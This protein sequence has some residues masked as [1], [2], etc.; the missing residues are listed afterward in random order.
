MIW[1]LA[2]LGL[3]T[4]TLVI[5]RLWVTDLE[6]IE[7][8]V[9]G[10]VDALRRSDGETAVS[11]LA[12]DAAVTIGDADL[13]SIR[14]DAV[15]DRRLFEKVLSS[16][17]FDLLQIGRLTIKVGS[18]TR[19]GTARFKVLATGSYNGNV[20][21]PFNAAGTEWDLG[22]RE[23]APGVWKI[24]RITPTSLPADATPYVQ[25]ILSGLMRRPSRTQR[26]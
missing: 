3:A 14:G 22:C 26:P 15:L 17:K 25:G 10:L 8:V 5:E 16:T 24:E 20:R 7:T 4:A 2:C 13:G 1:A 18:R 12:D 21:V 19:R 23:T 11:F 9:Y 6:R